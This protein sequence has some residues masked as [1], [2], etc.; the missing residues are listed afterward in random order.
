MTI[1]EVNKLTQEFMTDANRVIAV[2]TPEKAGVTPPTEEQLRAVMARVEAMELEPY[3]DEVANKPLVEV[4]PSSVSVT[5]EKKYDD[6]DVTEWTLSN[7]VKV[8]FKQTNF[9][10]DE[11]LFGAT[12]P[13]GSSLV[14]TEDLPSAAMA[15]TIVDMGGIADLDPIQLRKTLTGK[16][17]QVSP[18][19][20]EE[21][22]GFDGS[23]A[24]KDMETAFQLIYLYFNQPRKDTTSFTSF[25][26]RMLSMFENFSNMP[27]RVWSDTLTTTLANYHPRHRPANVEWLQSIDLEKAYDIYR[28]R[29]RDASDF[30]FTFVGN[31]NPAELKPMVEKYLGQLPI[32]NRKETWKDHNVKP[33]TGIV[34]KTVHK[35][36]D[37]KT[38]VAVIFSGD[39]DWTYEN[40]YAFTSL[41]EYLNIML[42]ESIREEKGGSYGVGVNARAEKYP[43]P[44]YAFM[45]NFGTNPERV[46]EM[47]EALQAVMIDAQ[48]NPA[49]AENITKIKEIQRRE[50]EKGMKENGFWMSQ[51]MRALSLNEPLNQFLEFEKMIDGL[52]PEMILE[53]ARKYIHLEHYVQVVLMPEEKKS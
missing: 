41:R 23:F 6:I 15:A 2:S 49:S 10:A 38:L 9:K 1:R 20:G 34:K 7:G 31:V 5:S 32:T 26:T 33:P 8:L 42:R 11:V 45:I 28:D 14:P 19:I 16:V 44:E 22:E 37:D 25:K 52:T 40:R 53:A 3:V 13:G 47:L 46:D 48:T 35:G 21:S 27:E 18:S 4:G 51:M 17:V 43:E 36:V 30:T 39:F 50:R 29:F 12:S 24:P